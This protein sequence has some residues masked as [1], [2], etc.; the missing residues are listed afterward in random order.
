MCADASAPVAMVQYCHP[1]IYTYGLEDQPVVL[2]NSV[3]IA[4]FG[5]LTISNQELEEET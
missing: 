3:E 2:K 1:R 4:C 5:L